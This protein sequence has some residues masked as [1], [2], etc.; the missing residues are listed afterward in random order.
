MLVGVIAA[1]TAVLMYPS[2]SVA[3]ALM[4]ARNPK[5]VTEQLL[6]WMLSGPPTTSVIVTEVPLEHVMV[7]G[8]PPDPVIVTL[9]PLTLL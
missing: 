6:I 1:G 9:T 7:A 4:V 2:G 5:M 8:F 3:L